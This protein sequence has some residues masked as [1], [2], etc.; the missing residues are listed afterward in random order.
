MRYLPRSPASLR[1]LN[2]CICLSFRPAIHL[3]RARL[4]RRAW[5]RPGFPISRRGTSQNNNVKPLP[6]GLRPPSLLDRS[7]LAECQEQNHLFNPHSCL[8]AAAS[9]VKGEPLC[10]VSAA[11]AAAVNTAPSCAGEIHDNLED[12]ILVITRHSGGA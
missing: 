8:L 6:Q 7:H 1:I 4:T 10:R 5:H 2:P 11:A 3:K 12:N 9:I